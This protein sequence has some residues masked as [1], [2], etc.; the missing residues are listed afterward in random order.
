MVCLLADSPVGFEKNVENIWFQN[1]FDA[2]KSRRGGWGRGRKKETTFFCVRSSSAMVW[3]L[4]EAMLICFS[5]TV[6]AIS[7]TFE[8][9]HFF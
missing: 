7:N 8:V 2:R 3:N 9:G 6:D 1:S 4:M 5:E